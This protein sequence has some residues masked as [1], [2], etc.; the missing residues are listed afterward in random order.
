[1][2]DAFRTVAWVFWV[3]VVALAVVASVE[4]LALDDGLVAPRATQIE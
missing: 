2:A 3:G 1:M 4:E